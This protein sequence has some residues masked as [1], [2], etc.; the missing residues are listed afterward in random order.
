MTSPNPTDPSQISSTNNPPAPP[1]ELE[2]LQ[3]QVQALTQGFQSF[4]QQFNQAPAP[5]QPASPSYNINPDDWNDSSRAPLVVAEIVRKEVEHSMAPMN[6]FRKSFERQN[7]YASIKA[8]VRNSNP[9]ISTFWAQIEPYLD[10]AFGSGNIDVNAQLVQNQ[11]LAILG[12]LVV[13]NPGMFAQR[14]APNPVSM[15]SPSG[16]PTP[17]GAPEPKKLRELDPNE[18]MLRK[19]RGLTHEQFLLLQDGSGMIVQSAAQRGG[20]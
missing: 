3:R 18:E 17:S 10:S 2:I 13:Q 16:S 5:T 14:T 12:G 1:T 9:Q 11:A 19:A 7:A 4:A 8:Q 20:K 15:I 6:A